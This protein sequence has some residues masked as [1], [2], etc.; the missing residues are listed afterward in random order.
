MKKLVFTAIAM[1]AFS[2]ASMANTI[3]V[4]EEVV[5]AKEAITI[6]IKSFNNVVTVEELRIDDCKQAAISLYELFM[7][8]GCGSPGCG[9][10]NITFYNDLMSVC[11]K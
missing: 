7:D 11:Y 10:D 5:S 6:E 9:G 8:G 4:K 2:G 3:E 1:I